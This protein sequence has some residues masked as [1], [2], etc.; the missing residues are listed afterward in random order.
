[1]MARLDHALGRILRGATI[2]C[3]VALLFI[4]GGNVLARI[5]NWFAMSWYDEVIEFFFAWMVFIG[6]A[7]LWRQHEHFRI[8]WLAGKLPG[9]AR[10]GHALL[11]SLVNLFFLY[12]LFTEGL[13][14]TLRS[15][16][17]TP[18]LRLP[19]SLLY[20]CIPIGAGIMALYSLRDLA[21]VLAPGAFTTP[22]SERQDS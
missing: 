4:L 3:L 13:N 2:A 10:R 5:S 16:A 9:H 7:A 8:D 18:I 15:A 20:A 17:L 14:L 6:A 11:V 19:V 22:R 1:M 21:R 12:F